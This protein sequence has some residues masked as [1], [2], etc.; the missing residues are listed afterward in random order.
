MGL[1]ELLNYGKAAVTGA[2]DHSDAIQ[3]LLNDYFNAEAIKHISHGRLLVS[4]DVI[5]SEVSRIE[6]V[7]GK[8]KELRC[9]PHGIAITFE[10]EHRGAKL[11]AQLRLQI[12]QLILT[13]SA[14][15]VVIRITEEKRP[16]GK[17]LL[18]KIVCC[19]GTTLIGDSIGF[20]LKNCDLGDYTHY[21]DAQKLIAINL[22]EVPEVQR[23]LQP[24]KQSWKESFPLRF[25]GIEEGIHVAGGVELR[26]AVAPE[27]RLAAN[28]L[29]RVAKAGLSASR[30][31]SKEGANSAQAPITLYELCEGIWAGLYPDESSIRLLVDIGVQAFVNL[32]RPDEKLFFRLGSYKDLLPKTAHHY[33]FPLYSYQLPPVDELLRIVDCLQSN[34]PSY[35]HCRQGLDR[36]GTIAV[37][38]LMKRGMNLR[39]SLRHITEARN[40]MRKPSPRRRY[41]FRYLCNAERHIFGDSSLDAYQAESLV[42]GEVARD[43]A[44]PMLTEVQVRNVE[45]LKEAVNAEIERISVKGPKAKRVHRALSGMN[46]L[47]QCGI[48]LGEVNLKDLKE[49]TKVLIKAGVGPKKIHAILNKVGPKLSYWLSANYH[50]IEYVEP[51][52]SLGDDHGECILALKD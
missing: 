9:T 5:R 43:K 15:T 41:H 30:T 49:I 18:G 23:L 40:G 51:D 33:R 31:I 50:E 6:G 47:V 24:V 27:L 14:Q 25:L 37:L 17:N 11:E 36:T 4:E 10:G 2:L 26:I 42:L 12:K 44:A 1:D 35:L 3:I 16:T 8:L 20:I 38:T 39:D 29:K 52:K 28:L 13:E 32:T 22:G 19:V 46:A 34:P 7:S 45:D 48:M 21:D